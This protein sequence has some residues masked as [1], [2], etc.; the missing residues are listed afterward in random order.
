MFHSN[1]GPPVSYR[2]QD[3]W[4]F[5]SKIT[6]ISHPLVFC[7]PLKGFPLELCI[8]TRCQK[9]R[10]IGNCAVKKFDDIFIRLDA[11]N[12]RDGKTDRQTDRDGWTDIGR[13]QRP[14][15][16]LVSCG[17][18]LMISVKYHFHW[19]ILHQTAQ[20]TVPQ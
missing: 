12:K 4:Q 6:K 15:L 5:P 9:T 7:G 3:R 8:S 16:C 2:F 13:Q 10:M 11:M 20:Q 19:S 18:K 14:R 1:H 17:N